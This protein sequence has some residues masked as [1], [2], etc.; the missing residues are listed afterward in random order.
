MSIVTSIFSFKM[1]KNESTEQQLVFTLGILSPLSIPVYGMLMQVSK[2]VNKTVTRYW[3]STLFENHRVAKLLSMARTTKKSKGHDTFAK[4]YYVCTRTWREWYVAYCFKFYIPMRNCGEHNKKRKFKDIL[5][6]YVVYMQ[7]TDGINKRGI[8]HVEL[9][10]SYKNQNI[11]NV[12]TLL[13]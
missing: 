8:I 5:G 12:L 1:A 9:R 13:L 10:N 11:E 2:S 7:S 3:E 4:S 6:D